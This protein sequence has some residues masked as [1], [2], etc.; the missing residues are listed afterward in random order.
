MSHR[1]APTAVD[2]ANPH[3]LVDAV[4]RLIS[5]A[6]T[7]EEAAA[8]ALGI[9]RTDVV[10]LEWIAVRDGVTP[11]EL[12]RALRY[13]S[14]GA[15]AVADRLLA[16]GLVL[17]RPGSSSRRR[18]VLRATSL[19]HEGAS[20]GRRRLDGD[21]RALALRLRA[22]ELE[23]LERSFATMAAAIEDHAAELTAAAA[24]EGA[25]ARGIP[26]PVRWG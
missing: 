23:L 7:R 2:D 3:P 8:A 25:A 11:S 20:V 22:D 24:A 17:R 12:A 4:D 14:G 6:A 26:R 1:L 15:T 9:R 18:V 13:S 21:L 10:A 19:G 5:A 16:A